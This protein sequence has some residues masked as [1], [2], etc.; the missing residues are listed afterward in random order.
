M[1]ANFLQSSSVRLFLIASID[2]Y[3]N[4]LE[5]EEFAL[6]RRVYLH[7]P[8]RINQILTKLIAIK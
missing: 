3:C 7:S 4:Q 1:L 8:E 2:I 5:I 6:I